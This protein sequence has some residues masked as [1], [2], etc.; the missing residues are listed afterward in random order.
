MRKQTIRDD[1]AAGLERWRQH[2]F[3]IGRVGDAVHSAVEAVK[4][5]T[6]LCSPVC[7]VPQFESNKSVGAAWQLAV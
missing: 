7:S 5:T 3:H 4:A 1:D 6:S 2:L